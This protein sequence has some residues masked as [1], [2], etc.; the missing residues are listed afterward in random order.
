MKSTGPKKYDTN[1]I[2]TWKNMSPRSEIETHGCHN[3]PQDL[4]QKAR[5]LTNKFKPKTL[6]YTR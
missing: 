4:F 5:I 3:E 1:A 6:D 2:K